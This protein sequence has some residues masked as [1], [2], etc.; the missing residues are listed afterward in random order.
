MIRSIWSIYI[1][2]VQY[3]GPLARNCP[4]PR[5]SLN[6]IKKRWLLLGVVNDSFIVTC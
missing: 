6:P 4:E 1:D 2:R 3:V 5:K